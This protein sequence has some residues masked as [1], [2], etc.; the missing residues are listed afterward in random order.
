M[1]KYEKMEKERRGM[2]ARIE[3]IHEEIKKSEFLGNMVKFALVGFI[4]GF[5]FD[6]IKKWYINKRR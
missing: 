4:I 2:F 6:D 5:E 3:K 1:N